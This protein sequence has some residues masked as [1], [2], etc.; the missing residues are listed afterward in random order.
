MRDQI[1]LAYLLARATDTIADA[2]LIPPG[3]SCPFAIK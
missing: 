1:G 2:S 3:H